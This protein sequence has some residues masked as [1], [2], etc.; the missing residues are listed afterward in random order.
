MALALSALTGVSTAQHEPPDYRTAIELYL[1]AGHEM[2]LQ[3]QMRAPY[4]QPPT[5]Q[6]FTTPGLREDAWWLHRWL[7]WAEELPF[8]PPRRLPPYSCGPPHLPPSCPG[9]RPD[10]RCW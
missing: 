1:Q 7:G 8:P 3:Q 5:V 9:C 4:V 2:A 6:R 10:W